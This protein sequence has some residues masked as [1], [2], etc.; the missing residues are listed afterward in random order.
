[1]FFIRNLTLQG[2]QLR[3][4]TLV[5]AEQQVVSGIMYYLNLKAE[6][7][8]ETHEYEARVWVQPWRDFKSLEEFT[9]KQ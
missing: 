1:M 8:G 4:V 9:L 6:C 5:S 2:L 7:G 3:F